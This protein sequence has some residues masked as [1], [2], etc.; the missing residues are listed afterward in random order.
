MELGWSEIPARCEY[1]GVMEFDQLYVSEMFHSEIRKQTMNWKREKPPPGHQQNPM[2][3]LD[4]RLSSAPFYKMRV[5]ILLVTT[6]LFATVSAGIPRSSGTKQPPPIDPE[7]F[8]EER[9]TLFNEALR[10]C[11]CR[12]E[13]MASALNI[14]FDWHQILFSSFSPQTSVGMYVCTNDQFWGTIKLEKEKQVPPGDIAFNQELYGYQKRCVLNHYSRVKYWSRKLTTGSAKPKKS[15]GLISSYTSKSSS[16]Q[17]TLDRIVG[18]VLRK[19]GSSLLQKKPGGAFIPPA[20]V[21]VRGLGPIW[22]RVPHRGEHGIYGCMHRTTVRTWYVLENNAYLM[23][24]CAFWL[25]M[26]SMHIHVFS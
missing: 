10:D 2:S 9:L 20:P 23:Y 3:P 6:I 11:L 22:W 13:T 17:S 25:T 15:Y 19:A 16:F 14:S 12:N 4:I 1:D 5:L 26:C 18:S 7:I 21:P 24:F 8:D